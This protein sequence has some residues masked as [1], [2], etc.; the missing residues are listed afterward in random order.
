MV[1]EKDTTHECHKSNHF[2]RL[3]IHNSVECSRLVSW[4]QKVSCHLLFTL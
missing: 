4:D 2:F 3:S 1:K